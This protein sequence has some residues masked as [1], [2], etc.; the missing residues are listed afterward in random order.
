MHLRR[1][2]A[3]LATTFS[4]PQDHSQ[5]EPTPR[6]WRSVALTAILSVAVT[7][8]A[9]AAGGDQRKEQPAAENWVGSWATGPAG[10]AGAAK[11]YS[12]QTIRLIVHTSVGG[13]AVRIKISNTFGSDPLVIGTAHIALRGQAASIVA[14][15]DHALT[16]S[17]KS[18]FTIPVGGLIVSD[19]VNLQVPPLSDLAVSIYLP[20]AATASTTHLLAL[21]TSYIASGAG[22]FTSAVNLPRATTITSWDFLTGVDV[23]EQSAGGTIV[24]LGDSITD[25]A[26]ST[27]DTNHR[28]PSLLAAR[29]QEDKSLSQ[30]GVLDEGIIGNRIL[31]PTETSFGNLFGPSALARFDRDVLSQAGVKYVIVLLGI[32]DIGHPGGSAPDSEKVS[33]DD[34]IAGHLQLIAR[35][36]EKGLKIYGCTLM[37]FENTTLKNFYSPEKEKLRQAVN[38]WMRTSGAYDAV[39]DF[40]K[41]VRDPGHPSRFLPVYDGGDHLHP[42]DAGQKAMA[43]AIDLDLFR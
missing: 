12:N 17:G 14:G 19:P 27:I 18:S 32:N 22:D 8:T 11:Q 21:Q 23:S 29:L 28:W 35:A 15:S 33:S 36:H 16:F 38:E 31:H 7:L 20:S 3:A 5:L 40:D 34:I 6:G 13:N 25:G 10:P 37:P 30:L 39:I 1:L 42:S 41:V 43:N 2:I 9:F 24:A 4:T 26:N